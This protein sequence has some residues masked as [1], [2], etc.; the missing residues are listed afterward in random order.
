MTLVL[1]TFPPSNELSNYLEHFLRTS[2]GCPRSVLETLHKAYICGQLKS[3]PPINSI[4]VMRHSGRTDAWFGGERNVT[5]AEEDWT[6]DE[7]QDQQTPDYSL[8]EFTKAAL[9]AFDSPPETKQVHKENKQL[10][11]PPPPRR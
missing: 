1:S 5:C 6:G 8:C 10:P 7:K 4:A 9:H 11:P 2:S 3:V